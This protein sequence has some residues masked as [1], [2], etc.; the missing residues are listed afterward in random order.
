[1]AWFLKDT[2]IFKNKKLKNTYLTKDEKEGGS[3]EKMRR[4]W[5]CSGWPFRMLG[6]IL[7]I[8]LF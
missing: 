3:D 5:N 1:M 4:M 2:F 8:T 7:K 6:V